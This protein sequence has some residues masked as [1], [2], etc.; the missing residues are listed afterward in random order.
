MRPYLDRA[1]KDYGFL[2]DQSYGYGK[3]MEL[4]DGSMFVTYLATGVTRPRTH[5]ET[6]SAA[7]GS[8]APRLLGIDLLPHR[9]MTW[10]TRFQRRSMNRRI[11]QMKVAAGLAMWV[12]CCARDGIAG[13]PADDDGGRRVGQT[14]GNRWTSPLGL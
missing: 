1:G 11:T 6:P 13:F 4:P 10:M 14:G 7:S 12:S 3:A 2:V 5:K 8:G 9:T